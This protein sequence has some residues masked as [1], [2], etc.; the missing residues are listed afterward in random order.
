[1]PKISYSLAIAFA[2]HILILVLSTF[3]IDKRPTPFLFGSKNTISM[4][5]GL[6]SDGHAL[7]QSSK[8]KVHLSP[9]NKVHESA[10]TEVHSPAKVEAASEQ[11][12]G[13][14]IGPINGASSYDFTSSAVSYQD[15]TYPRLAIQRELEG[16]V[17]VRVKVTAEGMPANTEI[18]KSSGHELL[19]R[20]ALDAISKWKFHPRA[21]PY[22]VEKDI[23]FKLKN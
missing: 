21:A 2:I 6:S 16:S 5:F 19:D 17:T 22:F 13:L 14:S 7:V 9:Q 15:P 11:G 8:K 3:L 18:L 23:I 4:D 12:G 20:A 1:M 10:G